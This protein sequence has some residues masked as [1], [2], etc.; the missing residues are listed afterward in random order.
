[1]VPKLDYFLSLIGALCSSALALVFPPVI[2]LVC[3]WSSSSGPSAM[4]LTKNCVI[5]VVAVFGLITGTYESLHALVVAFQSDDKKWV[6][7][8]SFI[9]L[10]YIYA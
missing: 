10:I 2:E 9:N 7:L 4:M 6:I 1:M 3:A 5:M 8:F